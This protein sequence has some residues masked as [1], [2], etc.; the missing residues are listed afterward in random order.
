MKLTWYAQE[1]I[2]GK[3]NKRLVR[4]RVGSEKEP[5]LI[6]P[7]PNGGTG[8]IT[9]GGDGHQR[10]KFK[11]WLADKFDGMT[12]T[13]DDIFNLVRASNPK[14]RNPKAPAWLK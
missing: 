8:W 13:F 5:L 1:S 14:P 10:M 6:A 9:R 11:D 12:P 7:C 4:F 2:S 3:L